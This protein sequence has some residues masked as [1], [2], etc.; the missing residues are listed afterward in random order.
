MRI[1]LATKASLFA[2]AL[3][4]GSALAVGV[5]TYRTFSEALIDRERAALVN[6]AGQI[7]Q[8][9]STRIERVRGDAA[10][11][12]GTQTAQGIE[13]AR[14]AGGVD[15]AT[16][17]SETQ[18]RGLLEAT[19]AQ[20]LSVRSDY[21]RVRLIGAADG[22]RE[23][24]RVERLGSEP[25]VVEQAALQRVGSTAYFR[26]SI[27]LPPDTVYLSA[28]ELEREHDRIAEPRT[29][30][31]R[32]AVAIQDERGAQLGI[33][34]VDL[35]FGELVESL[36]KDLPAN[37][38]VYVLN[39]FGDFL[40]HPDPTLAFRFE[41]GEPYRVDKEFPSVAAE[42]WAAE[43]AGFTALHVTSS[44]AE[45]ILG[46]YRERIDPADPDRRIAVVIDVPTELVLSA[47]SAARATS[48]ALGAVFIFVSIGVGFLATQRVLRSI[49]GEPTE[50]EAITA[51]VAGGDLDIA[52]DARQRVA[53]GILGSVRQMVAALRE[54]R[55]TVNERVWLNTELAR[56]LTIAQSQPRLPE[57]A[58]SVITELAR[59]SGA[60]AG[61]FFARTLETE[62]DGSLAL[63]ATFAHEERTRL[64]D[65]VRP[66]DGLVGQC[67][68]ER[69][70]ILLTSVPDEYV[71]IRSGLGRAAPLQV[72][73]VPVLSG[74]DV[75]AAIELASFEPFAG[76]RRELIDQVSATLGV[77]VSGHL[78]RERTAKL[79][80]DTQ[81]LSEETQAQAEEL[82][83]A[84]E[85]LEEKSRALE[86][87]TAEMEA[88]SEELRVTN[89]ELGERTT[90]LER[91][92]AQ[93]AV[94]NQELERARSEVERKATQVESASAYKSE[95]LANMSHELRTPLNSLLILAR[96]LRENQKG[97]LTADQIEAAAM[98][99]RGGQDLLQ[100]INDILDLSKVE[101]GKLDLQLEEV[102]PRALARELH[103]EFQPLAQ[104][105]GLEL[106][107]ESAER[108]PSAI[109]TDP[110][111][112]RQ[113]LR[114]LLSNAVKFTSRGSVTLRVG[115]ASVAPD[116]AAAARPSR[117]A[118]AVADTGTGI[119]ADKLEAIFGAFQQADGSITRRYGGT[120]LGL[121]ISRKL[122][123]LL[124]GEI[125]VESEEGR[126]SLFTL[127]LPQRGP[128]AES[129]PLLGT[130]P[131]VAP[132]ETRA[133][134]SMPARIPR[135]PERPRVARSGERTLLIIED[136]E[137]FGSVLSGLA[138]DRG[139]KPLLA[140]SGG[141]GLALAVAHDPTA[142]LL[143]LGLPDLDGT[144]VLE[145]LK[146]D[147]RTRHIPVHVISGRAEPAGLRALGALGFLRK[148]VSPEDLSAAFLRIESVLGSR[149]KT[150]L[151]VDDDATSRHAVRELLESQQV[152]VIEAASGAEART[153]VRSE[154]CDCIVLDL[155][156]GDMNGRDLLRELA[157]ELGG[158]LPAVIV[159]TGRELSQDEN[160]SLREHAG[161][162]VVKGA[163]S[164]E[165]LLDEVSLFLHSVQGSLSDRQQRILHG[166]HDPDRMLA[167]RVVLVVDDDMRNAYALSRLLREHQLE[168][169]IADNGSIA[170]E[171][172]ESAPHVDL[173]LMDIMMPVMDGFEAMRRIRADE[174]H[175]N[176]PIIALTAKA[177]SEDR[178][179]CLLAGANDYLAKPVDVDRL[180]S[181]LRV[182]LFERK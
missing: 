153:L 60:G 133:P 96:S 132:P 102:D 124:G 175:K 118:F 40:R 139:Y 90:A 57:L 100:L 94:M 44:G 62:Q 32:A 149:A 15:A 24:V 161:T 169:L 150:V 103:D 84:N 128:G 174:R 180:L 69:Q 116:G 147:L 165:R 155:Q 6:D 79:L 173:V 74:D 10:F 87:Q 29:P 53:M 33:V 3:V 106:Q 130:P 70:P 135:E 121:A 45:R 80:V 31:V 142:I 162:I 19:F 136:D 144:G 145:R 47:S 51:R 107:L 101:A 91:Q 176:L 97:N 35:A 52:F 56:V 43:A 166:L 99:H 134:V 18:Y 54:S 92:N 1:G 67:A 68:L 167:G 16:G 123:A 110:Q 146:S 98:I 59:L 4:L 14:R 26:E 157:R 78:A 125:H 179:R 34:I 72:L 22:G 177:M 83:A 117:T 131:L 73:V 182:W 160:R 64:P 66:G 89:E 25:R 105:A 75:V 129:A 143:D 81:R 58:R 111:R 11:L 156:L 120:G 112:L 109:R 126:G 108:A 46:A 55:R 140:E 49:G 172:L 141:A 148:P 113:I 9:I 114:N 41:V 163:S 23:L 7:A 93:A 71:R 164:P 13:R 82:R 36:A 104:Q 138:R 170:L 21:L 151:V 85:E 50:I 181:A 178:D 5:A 159:Y 154:S 88:Q 115:D 95:F 61:A 8:R 27:G 17:L 122:A 37:R 86:Q 39:R 76:V 119:P 152:R 20:L 168:V 77:I 171:Q 28:I 137:T 2:G 127:L 65:R 48:L 42:L 38:R 12:A 63:L 158:E 30:V